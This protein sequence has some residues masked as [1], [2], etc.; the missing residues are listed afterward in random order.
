MKTIIAL[1][2]ALIC[3]FGTALFAQTTEPSSRITA[4]DQVLGTGKVIGL[5]EFFNHQIRDGKPFHYIWEDTAL[6]GFSKFGDVWKQFGAGI[7]KLDKAP[8][9]D[10]LN[11][12]S[13]YLV[14]NPTPATSKYVAPGGPNYIQQADADVVAA[15][16]NDGGVLVILAN[17]KNN[18]EFEHLNILAGKFG[19]T[20]NGDLRNQ[21]PNGRDRSPGTFKAAQFPDHPLFKDI[22]MIYMKEISTIQVKDPAK[23]MFIVDNEQKTGKD[24]IMATCQYG[25][26]FVFALGDPWIYNEYIDVVS[27]PGLTLEN[28]K[29]A[30]NLVRWLL[31][32]SSVP[33]AK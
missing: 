19:I 13:I 28:R 8:T 17:D 18:C 27:T 25:K 11:K 4:A 33:T 23:P 10:D 16:V 2:A 3:S 7:T 32:I 14:V 31:P 9:R 6:S 5:D 15:W 22:S 26:G 29:G 30:E 12:L 21:V 24:I 1:L 20:F